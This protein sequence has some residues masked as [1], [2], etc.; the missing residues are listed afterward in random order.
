MGIKYE[1][2]TIT[3]F[4]CRCQCSFF[5]SPK[6]TVFWICQSQGT[7]PD[8]CQS[9]I[10]RK[11]RKVIT[12]TFVSAVFTQ[13]PYCQVESISPKFLIYVCLCVGAITCIPWGM[14]KSYNISSGMEK[15]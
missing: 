6:L 13:D 15:I 9:Q 8:L 4:F 5:F 7:R 14:F 3:V 10:Y 2:S 11:N 12:N 1:W